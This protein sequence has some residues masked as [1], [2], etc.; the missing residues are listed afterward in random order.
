MSAT[1]DKRIHDPV[2]L[3]YLTQLRVDLSNLNLHKF[4]HIPRDTLNTMCRTIDGIEDVEV[5]LLQ[6]P[7]FVAQRRDILAK[8]AELLHPFLNFTNLS[9]EALVQLLLHGDNDLPDDLNRTILQL[10]LRFI[11]EI[12]RF[13]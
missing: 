10:T 5:F 12:G 9:N 1:L 2:E 8:V 4:K 3:S 13:G 7:S 6:C 11:Y